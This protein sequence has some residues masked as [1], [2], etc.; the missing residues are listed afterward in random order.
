[1][2]IEQAKTTLNEISEIFSNGAI[3]K[4]NNLEYNICAYAAPVG[5]T[6]LI[7]RLKIEF[8]EYCDNNR[9][10]ARVKNI[11]NEFEI[12]F[13]Y[14]LGTDMQWGALEQLQKWF[15]PNPAKNPLNQ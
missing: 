13:R 1:M 9:N 8:I 14:T 5:A 7:E 4:K 2:D 3:C 6:E 11:G 12:I 10:I 15:E